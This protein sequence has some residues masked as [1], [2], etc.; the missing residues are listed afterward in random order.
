MLPALEH[1]ACDLACVLIRQQVDAGDQRGGGIGAETEGVRR[2]GTAPDRGTLALRR[3]PI[4]A[5]WRLITDAE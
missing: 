4:A 5:L 2:F 1:A 3:E